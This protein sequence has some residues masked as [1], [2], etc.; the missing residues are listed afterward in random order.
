MVKEQMWRFKNLAWMRELKAERE[1]EV[2]QREAVKAA[3]AAKEAKAAEEVAAVA[4]EK[5]SL[6]IR[7][8]EAEKRLKKLQMADARPQTG[9]ADTVSMR[10]G[11]GSHRSCSSPQLST[12]GRPLT[13]RP[14]TGRPLTGRPLTGLDRTP[15]I[16]FHPNSKAAVANFRQLKA[17]NARFL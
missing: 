2:R 5:A 1:E 7:I 13:G 6:N 14:L 10:S 17:S 12:A 9:N 11:K 15:D 4:A 8:A 3:K 16:N